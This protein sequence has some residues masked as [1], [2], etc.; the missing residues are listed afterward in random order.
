MST[1]SQQE[2]HALPE[3]IEQI[4]IQKVN[5]FGTDEHRNAVTA[6]YEIAKQYGA[7]RFMISPEDY[8]CE[9]ENHE[10]FLLDNNL[11]NED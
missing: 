2:F 7:E 9:L 10:N 3:V 11:F 5:R 8:T 1:I 4:N 6:I